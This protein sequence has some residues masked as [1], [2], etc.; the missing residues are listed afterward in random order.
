LESDDQSLRWGPGRTAAWNKLATSHASIVRTIVDWSRVAPVR[1]RNPRNP[2]DRAYR[3]ADVDQLVAAA[4]RRGIEVLITLWGTPG[5]ANGHRKPNVPPIRSSDFEAFAEAVATRYSGASPTLGFVQFISIWNEPNTRRFLNARNRPAAYA[6]LVR[7]GYRGV[8]AGSP[9]TLVAAGETAASHSP[10][11]FVSAVARVDRNLPFDAWAHH[12]YPGA[13]GGRP[14]DGTRWPNVGLTSLGRFDAYISAEFRRAQ[15]PLWVT[16]YAESRPELSG[17][18]IADDVSRAVE[19]AGQVPAVTMFI[20][21]ML[22]N[23]RGEPWQSGLVGSA[24]LGSFRTAAA[25]LDPRNG[26]VAWPR[27]RE[28]LVVQVSARELLMQGQPPDIV[29]VTSTV[30]GCSSSVVRSGDTARIQRDGWVSVVVQPGDG[31]P[32][33]IVIV[34]TNAAGRQVERWFDV[35]GG[36]QIDCE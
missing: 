2:H 19:L 27:D 5:W 16:E 21:F 33:R 12:P 20:W 7:S 8:K 35:V 15:T 18:Q 24:A 28:P 3:F 1:P 17:T 31:R 6:A 36:A 22:N 25:A 9:R 30:A 29:A 34:L 26:R 32:T 23:H 11:A 4:G 13:A 14:D 10:A